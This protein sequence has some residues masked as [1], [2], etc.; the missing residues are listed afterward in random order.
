MSLCL[1]WF[2]H[3]KQGIVFGQM[4]LNKR[5]GEYLQFIGE[6][7]VSLCVVIPLFKNCP[8]G[9]SVTLLTAFSFWQCSTEF[10][11]MLLI[12]LRG[13]LE[14]KMILRFVTFSRF[15]HKTVKICRCVAEVTKPCFAVINLLCVSDYP[16]SNFKSQR[17]YEPKGP[18]VSLC[19]WFCVSFCLSSL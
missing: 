19:L 11:V 9:C 8:L 15:I 6:E 2:W 7:Y 1:S 4:L 5:T 18:L 3:H 13:Y 12:N 14:A 16:A 10:W 17:D